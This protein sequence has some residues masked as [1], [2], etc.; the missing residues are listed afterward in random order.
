MSWY[1]EQT[2]KRRRDETEAK[3]RRQIQRLESENQRLQALVDRWVPK[4]LGWG[5]GA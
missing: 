5:G 4:D 1:K 3:L 2:E